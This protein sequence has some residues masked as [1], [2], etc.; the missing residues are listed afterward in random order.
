[1]AQ[2]RLMLQGLAQASIKVLS[3]LGASLEAQLGKDPF[4]SSCGCWQYVTLRASA[5]CWL[6]AGGHPQFL[7]AWASPDG[8]VLHQRQRGGASIESA[9]KKKVAS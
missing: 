5:P 1:M 6:L 4:P 2:L 7:A 3:W 9:S 8:R